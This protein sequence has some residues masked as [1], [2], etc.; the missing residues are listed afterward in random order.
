[1]Q[2]KASCS[3]AGREG[4]RVNVPGEELVVGH[5]GL[6]SELQELSPEVPGVS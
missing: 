3:S 5:L 6:F 2:M 1:M 4:I